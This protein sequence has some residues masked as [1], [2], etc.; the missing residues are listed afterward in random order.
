MQTM[1]AHMPRVQGYGSPASAYQQRS[2]P[3]QHLQPSS[4]AQVG[5]LEGC[6]HLSFPSKLHNA[7][8]D[9]QGAGQAVWVAACLGWNSPFQGGHVFIQEIIACWIGLLL[10]CQFCACHQGFC[11]SKTV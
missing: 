5:V 3:C 4:L 7:I 10:G 11:S 6:P 2:T 1:M 8:C 9:G